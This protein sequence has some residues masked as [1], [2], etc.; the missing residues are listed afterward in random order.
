MNNNRSLD[1]FDPS[2]FQVIPTDITTV[3]GINMLLQGDINRVALYIWMPLPIPF[4]Q[5]WVTFG[6]AGTNSTR[7]YIGSDGQLSLTWWD[8]L[9]LVTQPVYLDDGGGGGL[10]NVTAI[11]YLSNPYEVKHGLSRLGLIEEKIKVNRQ[12]R[13]WTSVSTRNTISATGQRK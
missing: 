7:K 9:S 11:R 12:R 4:L 6:G 10:V 8:A 5:P 1:I 3:A 13:G 2:R